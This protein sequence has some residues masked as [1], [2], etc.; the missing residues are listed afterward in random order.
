MEWALCGMLENISFMLGGGLKN[1]RRSFGQVAIALNIVFGIFIVGSLGLVAY[2]MSRIL[3]AREQ[4]RH[5]LELTSLGGSVSLASSSLTGSA[6]QIAAKTVAM[7]ILK[8]N[9]VLGKSLS[10]SAVEVGSIAALNPAPGQVQV[11]FEFVDPITKLAVAS[12]TDTGVIKVHGAYAY[13]L[14]SGGFGSIGVST[15]TLVSEATAGMP[16]IDVMMVMNLSGS[17]DD[18]TK[19]TMIRRYWDPIS[20]DGI[21]YTIPSGSGGG[22]LEGPIAG[23]VCPNVQGTQLNAIEPQNL[24]AAGDPRTANCPAEFSEGGIQGR[25]VPLRGLT[26]MAPPGDTP[27]TGGVGIGGLTVGPG[28]NTGSPSGVVG[29]GGTPGLTPFGNITMRPTETRAGTPFKRLHNYLPQPAWYENTV[30]SLPSI[31]EQPASAHNTSV[32]LYGPNTYNPWGAQSSL[33]TDMVVNLD[34][35]NHFSGYTDP[36]FASYPFPTVDILVEAARGNMENGYVDP[37]AWLSNNI[38]SQATPGWQNAYIC[39]AYKQLQPMVTVENDLISFMNKMSQTSDCHFGFVGFSERAG[40]N[41]SDT[42]TAFASSY[43]FPA[44]GS[45]SYLVP[46][47]PI[48]ASRNNI[49]TIRTLLSPPSDATVPIMLPN[50]GSNLADGL[51]QAIDNLSGANARSGAMKAILVVTDQVPTRDLAGNAYPNAYMNGAA[52]GDCMAQADR[53]KTLGIPVFIVG[54]A[55]N[56]GMSSLMASQFDDTPNNGGFASGSGFSGNGIVGAAGAGGTTQID[57]WVDPVTTGASL[58][59]KLNNVARQLITLVQ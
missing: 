58:N 16:S 27:P 38:D 14:F 51:K 43:L 11:Y 50:G 30:A 12:G 13:P 19:V 53:A 34:G 7:N 59:G 39:S 41:S 26:D 36:N 10:S 5:C 54:V 47:V 49:A 2:E 52:F 33:F 37:E 31:F 48:D 57:T 6:G 4:L 28:Y 15:Y 35:N 40:L 17:M 44:S 1:M 29:S 20:D 46:Q 3:L 56:T 42:M 24:D 25:T 32:T 8:K 55:Q 9:S 18:Q 21:V 22:L 23:I 45:T